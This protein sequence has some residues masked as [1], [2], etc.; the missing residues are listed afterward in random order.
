L[1]FRFFKKDDGT[2]DAE[3]VIKIPKK[4][5]EGWI[6]PEIAGII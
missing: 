6:G 3:P 2:W 5:V 4:K 1:Y